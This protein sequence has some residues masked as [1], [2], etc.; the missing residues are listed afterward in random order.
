MYS[1]LIQI[2]NLTKNYQVEG[3]AVGA[4]QGIDL[5]VKEG[6]FLA[7]IGRSGCGKST[8][9][10]L[11]GGLDVP[12]SGVLRVAN[13]EVSKLDERGLTLYRRETVGIV[14]QFFN[15]MP[16]LSA[17]ENAALPA[18]LAGKPKKATFER[19]KNLLEAV[20]LE[21]R[22]HQGASLLS[23]GEMQRVALARALI[24]DPQLILADEPT[25]NLDSHSAQSVLD[26]L[27]NL[28]RR[29]GKTVVMVTHSLEAAQIADTTREMRDGKF[30]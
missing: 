21:N 1:P 4:L 13:Q 23:G 2:E 10:N 17:L 8:L 11:L 14:F 25:G 26:A 30:V 18:L 22:I 16:L 9:L 24:N 20:G 5:S 19:A 27:S 12:S 15:L 29:E 3:R 28:T 7:L 6:E